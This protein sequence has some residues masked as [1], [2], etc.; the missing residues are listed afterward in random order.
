MHPDY[1]TKDIKFEL[2]T[3][4]D[5]SAV[6]TVKYQ[7]LMPGELGKT[8]EEVISLP[9]ENSAQSFTWTVPA[10]EEGDGSLIIESASIYDSEGNET[11]PFFSSYEHIKAQ[12]ILIF[13]NK[14]KAN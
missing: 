9:G 1:P 14:I 5:Y 13:Q 2:K 7:V 3:P 4:P 10:P 8:F 11:N 6:L 12:S